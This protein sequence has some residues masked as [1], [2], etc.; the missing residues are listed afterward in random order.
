M[1]VLHQWPLFSFVC[2]RALRV[3]FSVLARVA[4]VLR[5][6]FSWRGARVHVG[7]CHASSFRMLVRDVC[8]YRVRWITI[9]C[10][11]VPCCA[12]CD[13]SDNDDDDDNDDEGG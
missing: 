9:E 13:D 6:G 4:C 5:V 7:P 1:H 10:C 11:V 2:C 8:L 3:V 12:P